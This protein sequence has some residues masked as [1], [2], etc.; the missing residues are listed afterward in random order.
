MTA[1]LDFLSMPWEDNEL[2]FVCLESLDVGLE[3]FKGS[4]PAPVIHSN[5]DSWSKFFGDTSC[6]KTKT[7]KKKLIDILESLDTSTW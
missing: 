2:S 6:L 5:A 1:Y 3:T 7:K 4:V